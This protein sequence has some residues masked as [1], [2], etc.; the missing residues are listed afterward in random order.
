MSDTSQLSYWSALRGVRFHTLPTS[1]LIGQ[2]QPLLKYDSLF[3]PKQYRNCVLHNTIFLRH[4]LFLIIWITL[5]VTL[6]S[7]GEQSR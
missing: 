4:V 1:F 6:D 3:L 2:E 7:V 5:E